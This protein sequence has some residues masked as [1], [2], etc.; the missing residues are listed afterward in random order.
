MRRRLLWLPPV[1]LLVLAAAL[2][3][4]YWFYMAGAVRQAIGDWIEARRQEGYSVG[5][6]RIGVSGFPF[7]FRARLDGAVLA[8][9]RA[10]PGYELRLP[11]LVGEAK[12]WSPRRWALEGE[13]GGR[14]HLDPGPARPSASI[15]A[16]RLRGLVEP[17]QAADIAAGATAIEL[18]GDDVVIQADERLRMARAS[19]SAV[20][21]AKAR[22]SHRDVWTRAA[23]R[24]E[25][26]A[27]PAGRGPLGG[28]VEELALTAAVKAAVPQGTLREAVAR[29]R[30]DGGTLE[31]ERFRLAWGRLVAVATGT[32]AL[33]AALQ[34]VGS[35][36]ATVQGHNEVLDT[37]VAD[38][39]MRTGDAALAKV[40]L[41]LL[42]KPAPD[43]RSQIETS[44][45]I[46][47]SE[48]FLGPA[49]IAR[50][51]RFTWE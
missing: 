6:D 43:G 27:L 16:A 39:T 14:L 33:D 28:T 2:Y 12:P 8:Q 4:A 13:R 42:A 45:R 49:R 9:D 18:A 11:V 40:A 46:Q 31:I 15:T 22:V 34:P 41:G 5:A 7:V 50:L 29:W 19:V 30:D 24:F 1:L 21:P 20:L 3:T 44:V 47:N 37:L 48:I 23:L 26:I 51:P 38:G 32:L 35:L 10:Q 17:S 25:Q 36:T